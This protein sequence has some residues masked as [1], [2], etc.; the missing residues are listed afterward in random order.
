MLKL[1]LLVYENIDISKF[2]NLIYFLKQKSTG[3]KTKKFKVFNATEI[4][5]FLLQAPDEDYLL[6]KVIFKCLYLYWYTT[7]YIVIGGTNSST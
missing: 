7:N 1:T 4:E 5:R 2:G 6:M 3:Y